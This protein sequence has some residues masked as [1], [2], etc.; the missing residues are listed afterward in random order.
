MK[1]QIKVDYIFGLSEMLYRVRKGNLQENSILIISYAHQYQ[2]RSYVVAHAIDKGWYSEEIKALL[3]HMASGRVV[4]YAKEHYTGT[5]QTTPREMTAEEAL[6]Y[7]S[8][9]DAY[10]RERVKDLID[11]VEA[12]YRTYKHRLDDWM[13]NPKNI[14]HIRAEQYRIFKIDDPTR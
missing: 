3:D 1:E 11:L 5:I 2:C 8:P 13:K 4:F 6:N 14:D 7:Q 9:N 12:A 10:R